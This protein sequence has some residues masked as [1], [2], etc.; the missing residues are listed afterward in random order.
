[1]GQ[2]ERRVTH[3]EPRRR[4]RS[5]TVK[6]E[7]GC[8]SARTHHLDLSKVCATQA[9]G[10]MGGELGGEAHGQA[11]DATGA[12]RGVGLL[13]FREDPPAETLAVSQRHRLE[14]RHLDVAHSEADDQS[15]LPRQ[16]R[17]RSASSFA[18]SATRASSWPST[19]T[20][21][22]GSVPL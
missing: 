5:T 6:A 12:A 17:R 15:T 1:V 10:A 3:T 21:T 7:P 9:E 2:R 4:V 18:I 20:R 8:L 22:L 14:A 13:A 16:R 11:F 19:I